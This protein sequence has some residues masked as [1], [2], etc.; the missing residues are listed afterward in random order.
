MIKYLIIDLRG[1]VLENTSRIRINKYISMSGFC[2]RRAADALIEQGKVTVDGVPAVMGTKVY[3]GQKI[4]V[5]GQCLN[6]FAEHKVYAFYKPVGYISSMS[7]EQGIGISGFFKGYDRVYPVG[8]LDKES[9]G[10]MLL[11]ND[12]EMM[13]KILNAAG[14][15][16]K[17]YLVKVDRDIDDN[18]LRKMSSGVTI[19]NGQ[20]GRKV[21]TAPCKIDRI[22]NRH[23]RIILIQGLNRQIRRMCGCLNYKVINLKRIRIMNIDIGELK[24]GDIVEIT[25]AKL[26]ELRR[27]TGEL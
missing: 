12:G 10:L 27:L 22:D 19:T 4:C 16:E 17:E 18:F 3:A 7:D 2:S 8:R 24:P 23:F 11:T 9:E 13:N 25:G 21:V 14:G 5:E 20:T 26:D 6:A 1:I 15:H